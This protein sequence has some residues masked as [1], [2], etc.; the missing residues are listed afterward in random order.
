MS[1]MDKKITSWLLNGS[2]GGVMPTLDKYVLVFIRV[3]SLIIYLII[4]ISLR[5][6]VGKKKRDQ[7]QVG[8]KFY[9]NDYKCFSISFSFFMYLYKIVRV[10]KL[11]NPKV[12]KI[13]VPKYN[14][15][16]YCPANKD[17]FLSMTIREE[18]ILEQFRP[19][20]GDTVVDIGAHIGRYTLISSKRVGQNGKVVAIEADP[21]VFDMLN[22]NV[23]LNH[24]TNV[25]TLN[26]AVFSE[27][28]KIKLFV[29]GDELDYTIRNTIMTDRSEKAGEKYVEV[30]ANT[31][32]NILQQNGINPEDVNWVKIDVE[33]AEYEV[34]RGA[35]NVLSKSNDIALLI[36]IH[37]LSNDTNYYQPIM[38]LL[39]HNNFKI[40]FEKTY[41]SGEKHVIAKKY[42]K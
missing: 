20:E 19:K 25:L 23:K 22:R 40:E 16:V 6:I 2:V 26:Y 33:G 35:T 7:A 37:N 31:L 41:P 36:E 42:P 29:P 13:N 14:Y 5:L 30:E 8:R 18:D 9:T 21:A 1:I 38:D 4:R 24:L 28:T 3:I 17:D 34:L 12:L 11:G 15:K 32:D 10:L 39:G 27:E